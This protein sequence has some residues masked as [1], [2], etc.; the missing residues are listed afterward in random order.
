L[1]ATNPENAPNYFDLPTTE[2]TDKPTRTNHTTSPVYTKDN[3]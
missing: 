3:P 1:G 2:P